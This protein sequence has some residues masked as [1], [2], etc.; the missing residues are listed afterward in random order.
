M[1]SKHHKGKPSIHHAKCETVKCHN[2]YNTMYKKVTGFCTSCEQRKK[3]EK[4]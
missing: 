4:R 1:R 3:R 2:Y